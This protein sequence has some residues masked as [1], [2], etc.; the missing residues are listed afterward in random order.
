MSNVPT[1]IL[2]DFNDNLLDGSLSPIVSLISTHGYTQLV[3]NPTTAQ[4]IHSLTIFITT[5]QMTL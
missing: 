1:V 2:G 4:D 5:N 3:N